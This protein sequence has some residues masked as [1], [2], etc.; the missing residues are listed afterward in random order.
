MAKFLPRMHAGDVDLTTS[1]CDAPAKASRHTGEVKAPA[2]TDAGR[3]PSVRLAGCVE[4]HAFDWL[5]GNR[6]QN[7]PFGALLTRCDSSWCT[8]SSNHTFGSR[9]PSRFRSGLAAGAGAA[10]SPCPIG[11]LSASLQ[12]PDLEV[13]RHQE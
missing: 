9:V 6:A 13:F 7:R 2:L 3:V 10:P 8:A 12:R 1:A 4:Q 5:P 11:D